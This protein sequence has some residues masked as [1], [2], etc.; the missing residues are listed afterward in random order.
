MLS[1]SWS[2][3]LATGDCGTRAVRRTR[4]KDER[5]KERFGTTS[6][7]GSSSP[8]FFLA[9]QPRPKK[10]I[11]RYPSEVIPS[12]ALTYT[13]GSPVYTDVRAR[14]SVLRPQSC[15]PFW[16]LS[17]LAEWVMHPA[18]ARGRS[19]NYDIS[20]S[21]PCIRAQL[22]VLATE[23]IAFNSLLVHSRNDHDCTTH[24]RRYVDCHLF[25]L[26]VLSLSSIR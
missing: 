26:L 9:L 7:R 20:F 1:S 2:K 5:E 10:A 23:L 22:A 19:M 17:R 13:R 25:F 8:S 14:S 11:N 12:F 24:D 6:C 16:T 4:G 3:R 18:K 21:R 15:E